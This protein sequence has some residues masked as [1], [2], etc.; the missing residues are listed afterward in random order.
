[1]PL[2]AERRSLAD[3]IGIAMRQQHHISVVQ[4]R[5]MPQERNA[6]VVA[7]SDAWIAVNIGSGFVLVG[8]D[9]RMPEVLGWS[10]NGEFDPDS[11]NDNL[12]YW[13]DSYDQEMKSD[14]NYSILEI[15]Q[16]SVSALD[17]KMFPLEIE[18]LCVTQWNQNDPYN[19]LCPIYTGTKRAATGCVATAMAQVMAC[20]KYPQ[21]GVGSH[22]YQWARAAGDTITL[23]ASFDSITYDWSLLTGPTSVSNYIPYKGQVSALMYQ[24]GVSVNMKY[25]SS[26][27][28]NTTTAARSLVQYFGYDSCIQNIKADILPADSVS[29]ILHMELAEGRPVILSGTSEQGTRHAFILDG[30][31]RDGYYHVN[32]GWGGSSDGYYRLSALSPSGSQGSGS[33]GKTYGK[34]HTIIVGIKPSADNILPPPHMGIDSITVDQDSFPKTVSALFG[35]MQLPVDINVNMVRVQNFG[36]YDFSGEYGLALMD[37]EQNRI[38]NILDSRNLT[39]RSGYFRTGTNKNLRE[40][41]TFKSNQVEEG[42]YRLA[43]VYKESEATA[44]RIS[45]AIYSPSFLYLTVRP[46]SVFLSYDMPEIPV[47]T[48]IT[49]TAQENIRS[50]LRVYPSVLSAGEIFEIDGNQDGEKLAVRMYDISGRVV[51]SRD[52]SSLP[53]REKSPSVP[54][55]YILKVLSAKQTED[56]K[57]IVR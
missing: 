14:L 32:W 41:F 23:S 52:D 11:L 34:N 10:D 18:P 5:M 12:R 46:D 43:H 30:Y 44:W 1:M 56:T 36:L 13:L 50:G 40:V 8:A 45:Y 15:E 35:F 7:E 55:V 2:S 16:G 21:T 9:C 27:S 38:L 37:I 57:I 48:T 17:D 51:L 31:N 53:L 47:D 42:F 39:L 3:A 20:H 6:T 4:K 19:L 54:G 49:P 29:F 26:S 25:G 28:A 24:C 33:G 22:S